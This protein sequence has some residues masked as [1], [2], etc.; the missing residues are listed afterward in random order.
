[1]LRV[2]GQLVRMCVDEPCRDVL[3]LKLIETVAFVL[4]FMLLPCMNSLLLVT[5]AVDLALPVDGRYAVNYILEPL[6][7]R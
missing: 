5:F 7:G 4:V 3:M 2:G 6:F 1:M